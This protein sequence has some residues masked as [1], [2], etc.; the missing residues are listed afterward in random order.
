MHHCGSPEIVPL[1]GG[2]KRHLRLKVGQWGVRVI[3][4]RQIIS[5]D[6][7]VAGVQA[8]PLRS[9]CSL[10]H[11]ER[12]DRPFISPRI[13]QDRFHKT[14]QAFGYPCESTTRAGAAGGAKTRTIRER[15]DSYELE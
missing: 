8:S 12:G 1:L 13:A 9:P 7:L 5:Q 6:E 11:C 4:G 3:D 14:R 10:G 15:H 2:V